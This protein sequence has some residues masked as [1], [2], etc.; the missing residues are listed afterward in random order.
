VYVKSVFTNVSSRSVKAY[1]AETYAELQR[2][3]KVKS[4]GKRNARS[5]LL[6]TA[7]CI[8][9]WVWRFNGC[10]SETVTHLKLFMVPWRMGALI[11]VYLLSSCAGRWANAFPNLTSVSSSSAQAWQVSCRPVRASHAALPVAPFLHFYN[12]QCTRA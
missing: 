5:H 2:S 1:N 3:Q 6:I 11:C 8:E 4:R 7:I 9:H 12:P 10:S